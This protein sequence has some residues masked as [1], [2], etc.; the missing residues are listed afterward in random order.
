MILELDLYTESQYEAMRLI[1]THASA[2]VLFFSYRNI[3]HG[4]QGPPDQSLG[5]FLRWLK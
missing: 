2:A 3:N 4:P 1:T 5:F